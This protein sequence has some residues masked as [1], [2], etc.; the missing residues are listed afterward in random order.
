MHSIRVGNRNLDFDHKPDHCPI[1][2][3]GIEPTVLCG[4]RTSSSRGDD[5]NLEIAWRCT[6]R[7]CG[8]VFVARYVYHSSLR[9]TEPDYHLSE[10]IPDVFVP[11]SVPKEI[12]EVSPDFQ[13]ILSQA[14]EA[15]AR[16]LHDIAGPG[17][18]KSLE[19]LV[20]DYCVFLKPDE[21]DVVRDMSLGDCI[22]N[23][24]DDSRVVNCARRAA[25]LGNDETHYLRIWQNKDINDLKLLL[26]L[27]INWV[28]SSILTKKYETE[29]KHKDNKE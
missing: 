19:F 1:C 5:P 18:R 15:D 10:L 17:Y 22:S 27:T 23:R 29:M 7:D 16:G 8:R 13:R 4:S 6:W 12:A 28:Q 3:R 14:A 26:K 24:V 2:H 25:W 21:A 11:P 9:G 20:K